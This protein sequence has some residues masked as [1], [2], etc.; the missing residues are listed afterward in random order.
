MVAEGYGEGQRVGRKWEV[1][2]IGH[3][4]GF[5][6]GNEDVLKLIMAIVR[7]TFEYTKNH[8]IVYFNWVKC[9]ASES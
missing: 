4:R 5:F 2:P 1:T 9:M 7:H 6:F 3:I 8:S